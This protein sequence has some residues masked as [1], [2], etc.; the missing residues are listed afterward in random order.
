MCRYT[1]ERGAGGA[2][3][4]ALGETLTNLAG[5]FAELA[6]ARQGRMEHGEALDMLER[7]H[8]IRVRAGG[9]DDAV[10]LYKLH[11]VDSSRMIST[12]EPTNQSSSNF[13]VSKF[14]F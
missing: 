11:P 2:A 12:L 10:G 14:A 1:E 7:A 9:A 8:A 4:V 5:T 3:G 6:G 13:L